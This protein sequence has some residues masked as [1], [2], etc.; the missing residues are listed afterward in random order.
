MEDQKSLTKDEKLVLAA[1]IIG[2]LDLSGAMATDGYDV[3]MLVGHLLFPGRSVTLRVRG[4]MSLE[5][6]S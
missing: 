2:Y 4:F 6:H 1:K 3:L 5:A